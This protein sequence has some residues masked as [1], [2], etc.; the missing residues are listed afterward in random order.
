MILSVAS[1]KGGTGKTT[2]A[3]NLAKSLQNVQLLD[4]DVEE[5]NAHILLH[6]KIHEIEPVKVL[7]PQVQERKCTHCGICADFCE[8]NALF[9][10]KEKVLF[11]SE[12]CH[13]CGGCSLVCPLNAITEVEREIGKVVKGNADGIELVYGELKVGEPL[14]V[15]IIRDVKR[16]IRKEMNVILDAPPGTACPVVATVYGSDFCILVTEPTPFGLHDLEITVQVLRELAI[17][18]GVVVN[19]AGI[20]NDDVCSFCKREKI[21]ILLEIPYD[22][23]IAELYSQGIPFVEEMVEW[24]DRFLKL[25][26]NIERYLD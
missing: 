9:V 24:K 8:Y 16:R 17:P 26:N 10:S 2:V 13:S 3:C 12:L 20:G 19:T 4:C 21:P 23:R 7:V 25:F 5:P 11:F 22:R 6:P 14:A 15:P 1:G 18:M